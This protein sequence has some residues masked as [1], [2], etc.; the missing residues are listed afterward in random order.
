M[1]GPAMI[2]GVLYPIMDNF[3]KCRFIIVNKEY[4]SSENFF[5][6]QKATNELDHEKIRNS[7]PG[8]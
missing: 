2:D 1:G 5:Q 8:M 6:A 3:Y 4:C 7:G